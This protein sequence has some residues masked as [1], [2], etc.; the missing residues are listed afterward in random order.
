MKRLLAHKL[1]V[2]SLSTILSV[3][4]VYADKNDGEN[5]KEGLKNQFF[6]ALSEINGSWDGWKLA[7][8]NNIQYLFL[9]ESKVPTED[10]RGIK[11]LWRIIQRKQDGKCEIF[12]RGQHL[13]Y[14]VSLHDL[15]GE[16]KYRNLYSKNFNVE[17]DNS[18][19]ILESHSFRISMNVENGNS[20]QYVLYTDNKNLSYCLMMSKE[21]TKWILYKEKRHYNDIE[22]LSFIGRGNKCGH[23]DAEIDLNTPVEKQIFVMPAEVSEAQRQAIPFKKDA[24]NPMVWSLPQEF[25]DYYGI[26][27]KTKKTVVGIYREWK[28]GKYIIATIDDRP[29]SLCVYVANIDG[30]IFN[31]REAFEIAE[32]YCG[33]Q[34]WA[35]E[36]KETIETPYRLY[37][38]KDRKY[39]LNQYI[40]AKEGHSNGVTCKYY[41]SNIDKSE[42]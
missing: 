9:V 30:R 10:D 5:D 1:M 39:I 28:V 22:V 12:L 16:M 3:Q 20:E 26:P 25:A 23:I 18:K 7:D 2:I 32:R 14:M 29:K 11:L 36:E 4:Q 24:K 15:P 31:D 6:E 38:T 34:D 13:Q 41:L 21:A 40:Y 35:I 33:K 17:I 27:T 8:H 19:N 37:Y 42:F